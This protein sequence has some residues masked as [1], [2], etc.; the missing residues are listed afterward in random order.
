M[1]K[2]LI[3]AASFWMA[4]RPGTAAPETIAWRGWSDEAFELA[5]K[6]HRLVLLDL[7]AVW[8]HWCHVMEETTYR[9]AKVVAL[10]S[11][12]FVPIQVDQDSRPDLSNRYE[13]YGWPA[14][15]I[16]D[17]T[18]REL[19][20][21]AGYI[22]P[23]RMASL[24]EA[25]VEDPTPGPSARAEAE[26][27]AG[28]ASLDP[29]LKKDLEALV[30]ARYDRAQGGWGFSKKYL[31]WDSVEYGLVRAGA[32]DAAAETMARETLAK[33]RKLIDPVWG[34]FDQYSDGGDWDH[35]HFEKLA[36]FQAEGIRLYAEAYRRYRDPADLAA[37]QD[38]H[39]YVRAFLTSPEGASYVSQ[40][41]DLVAGEHSAEYYA[42]DDAAR[43][44]RGVPRVDTHLYTR[45]TAWMASADVALYAAT[46]ERAFL[47]EAEAAARWIV[48]ERS[49]SGGG[50]RHDA[51]DPA[52]PYLGDTLAAGRAFLALY[53]ATGERSWLR[54]ARSAASD[55]MRVFS[56]PG[57]PGYV[58][59]VAH[60]R[61]AAPRPE[62][63]E[64]VQA[65]RFLNLLYRYTGDVSD[66]DGAEAA[67]RLLAAREVAEK[68]PAASVLLV[69]LEL[70]SEPTHLTVVGPR[71][72]SRTQAL[73]LAAAGLPGGY[74]RVELWDR[75]EG[76]LPRSDVEFPNLDAPAAFACSGSRCSLPAFTPDDLRKRAAKLSAPAGSP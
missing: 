31:D 74:K 25:V 42:L 15:I 9:D 10:I 60:G 37:A 33:S 57:V 11:D 13:E 48:K 72:D 17:A 50:Y 65:A 66:R 62:R 12:H 71:R 6:D 19:V 21:F 45:E 75:S 49:R 34:G 18:G 55:F 28:P 38:I 27:A 24:L 46:G 35:P 64:N 22:P 58:T 43:R 76:P 47:D 8:C 56:V 67:M 52:G 14:T 20:K 69:D 32:G 16:F 73:L 59:A 5:G 61:F 41:A 39:R 54:L 26:A 63:D 2:T 30:A 53:G 4:C 29:A 36:Q 70:T 3:L 44:A 40:D 51:V 7:G 1:R 68:F 23:A